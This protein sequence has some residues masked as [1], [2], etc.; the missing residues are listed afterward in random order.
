MPVLNVTQDDVLELIQKKQVE[1]DVPVDTVLGVLKQAGIERPL[2]FVKPLLDTRQIKVIK[3]DPNI[4]V[5][6]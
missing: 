3:G 2:S 1:G 4:F 6:L 5:A